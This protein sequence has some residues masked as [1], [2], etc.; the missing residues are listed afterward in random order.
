MG[1]IRQE[2]TAKRVI[3][4]S[5]GPAKLPET[6]LAQAQK[7]LLDH[8]DAGIS[9]M[10]MSHRS[11]EFSRILNN[12][13]KSLRDLVHIPDNYKIVFLQGGGSGQFS[14]IPLNLM[15]LKPGHSADYIVTGSWSAKAAQEA[16]KYGTVNLVVPKK[17]K[18]TSIEDQSTWKL[19]PEAS[20]VYY[21]A[22]ETIHGVEFNF[23]PQTNG[24]PLV[25][26]MSSNFLSRTIDVT[27]F[28]LIFAGAQ[29]NI[30]CAGVTVVII[31]EDL[32][33]FAMKVCPVIF[34]YQV[35]VGNN[36]LYNTPPTYSIYIMGLVFSWI[37]EQGGVE[38]M[39]QN[40]IQKSG[41]VYDVVDKSEGF[42]NCPL[43]KDCRSRMNIPVRIGTA[44]GDETLE[45]LFVKESTERGFLQL[46][47]HRSVGGIRV[48]LYNA[49]TV[50]ET[51]QLV[52]FMTEFLEKHRKA[53]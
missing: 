48:S 9:V 13:E 31:R 6:V 33:G 36:S 8:Q 44:E 26:D 27:K 50:D 41:L 22:N 51:R 37:Q 52:A 20:Y 21:C 47:G 10:E 30:G 16:E 14:A 12:A 40:A 28:G 46:K 25:C 7:E 11:A 32:I 19:N 17:K 24:V 2:S 38:Q 4:F 5:P 53:D 3:N 43:E 18:Y 1:D 29:K 42:Y 39:E 34:D 45:K 49:V 15:A 35:Q 23:V